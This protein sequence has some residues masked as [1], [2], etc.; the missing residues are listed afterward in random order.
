LVTPVGDY[1]S[2]DR[3][4]GC[5]GGPPG[6]G[7]ACRNSGLKAAAAARWGLEMLVVGILVLL[8]QHSGTIRNLRLHISTFLS[9]ATFSIDVV[10]RGCH[11]GPAG[12]GISESLVSLHRLALA[13]CGNLKCMQKSMRQNDQICRNMQEYAYYAHSICIPVP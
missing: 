13:T 2:M 6:P 10:Y 12:P 11:D 7:R 9:A 8:V 1:T 3:V 4:L 5:R